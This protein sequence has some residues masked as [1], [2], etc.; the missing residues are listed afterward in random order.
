MSTSGNSNYS[1]LIHKLDEFIRKYYKNLCIR[2]LIYSFAILIASFIFINVIEYFF[3]LSS[4]VRA[5]LFY[6]FLI[7]NG[8]YLY[9]NLI[10]HVLSYYR[11]GKIINHTQ[12]AEII[13]EHFS[14]IQDKLINTLQLHKLAGENKDLST[15]IQ[16]SI[17]QKIEQ[18]R[19]ISFTGAIDLKKNKKYVKYAAIPL[20]AF[21]LILIIS[22]SIITEGSER[23]LH[24]NHYYER[25]APFQFTLM[26]E[27]L[28]VMQ[29]DDLD[30]AV[31]L[32]GEEIPQ[33]IYLL[34]DDTRHKLEKRSLLE[35][36]Y[37]FKNLQK[38]FT[39]RLYASG[40]Y[41]K[42]YEISVLPKPSVVRFDVE[43]DYPAYLGKKKEHISNTGDLHIPQG[44]NVKWIF[45]AENT[46]RLDIRFNEVMEQ[47]EQKSNR[48]YFSKRVLKNAQYSLRPHNALSGSKDSIIYSIQI[49][50]DLYPEI[51]VNSKID[52][53]SSKT[54]YFMGDIKDDYGFKQLNFN[55]TKLTEGVKSE[56][57][58]TNIPIA[59]SKNRDRFF[60]YWDLSGIDIKA[61]DQIEYYFEI[62]DNDGVN[63]SK[64]AR[65]VMQTYKAPSVEDIAKK[66][67]DNNKSLKDKMSESI[68]Q[69]EAIQ[70]E[71]KKLN[72]QLLNKKSLSFDEKKK[73]KEL[74]EKQKEL[75]KT[76]EEIRNQNEQNNR[77]EQEFKNMDAQLLEKKKQLEDLF[78]NVLDEKTKEMIRQLEKMM[79]QNNKEMTQ[80]QLKQM[81]MD[82]KQL[83][84]EMDRML[85]LFKQLE[86]EQKLNESMDKLEELAK[87]QEELAKES[88]N[89]DADHEELAKK[90]E[91]LNKEMEEIKKDMQDLEKKNE[92]LENSQSFENP[93][94]EMNKISEEMKKSSEELNKNKK[95]S[96]SDMQKSASENMKEVLKKMKEMQMMGEAEELAFNMKALRDI[97][98]NLL[99]ISF[100]QEK[101]MESLKRTSINDPNYLTLT[102]KQKSLKDD[103]KMVED[104]LFALS[105]KVSQIESFVN[106]EIAAIN[107]NAEKS[108]EHLADRRTGEA[109]M[110]QQYVMTSVNNLAVMLSEV[111]QQMQ[112]EMMEQK[113]GGKPGQ[114][115]GKKKGQKPGQS[116]AK[117]QEELNKQMQQMKNGMKPGEKPG[118]GQMSEQ[119]AR[120]AA[121]QQAIRNALQELEKEMGKGGNAKELNQLKKEM[122]KTETDLYNKN[123]TQ[124]TL[125]RQ[126]E[127]MTRLLEAENALREREYDNKREAESGK[128]HSINY[129]ILFEEYQKTKMKELEL[130]KT[131]PP[132]LKPYYKEKVG[133]YFDG[134]KN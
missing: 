75:E 28:E 47:A 82:N 76:I 85:E 116:I 32:K 92:E 103:L 24:Y 132:T 67:E 23:L 118:R 74:L 18:L 63:G 59:K 4:A 73:I 8:L 31:K 64:S 16:A 124:E 20:S 57:V 38:S 81:Q 126:K 72:E 27:E 102:Q 21:L 78:E 122:E 83:E 34:V 97:L 115:K 86:F 77:E 99:K 45:N 56:L 101:T 106:K 119:M 130:Y 12:A 1:L 29:G 54:L 61:G 95:K 43:L 25:P 39:L 48:F 109:T 114:Q 44:T 98:E 91:E 26:K 68:K 104:S 22:P 13:G 70:R 60:Y 11:L 84:K 2:G 35:F 52:S 133:K 80:E 15:L 49:I 37:S 42:P 66:T 96:A 127:I 111:L 10:R 71:A 105:K 58:S 93:E 131:L 112:E 120:M 3:Y 128:E 108:I 17:D 90:Q 94:Q 125:N 117:M 113:Q 14:D 33:D 40:F 50:P 6:S 51:E 30:L 89:K 88:L 100:D 9:K 107:L 110:R 65:T 41:S 62:W 121:Q 134:L 19:P 123:I 7:I 129:N 5:L 46:D 79:E 53:L 87:K 55:Y 69:S 36:L